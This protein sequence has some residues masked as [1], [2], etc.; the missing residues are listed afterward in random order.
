MEVIKRFIDRLFGRKEQKSMAAM[1][2]T[3]EETIEE[4][5]MEEE[6]VAEEVVEEVGRRSCRGSQCG[7]GACQCCQRI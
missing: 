7:P 3:T 2:E 1:T 5:V 6:E 4:E